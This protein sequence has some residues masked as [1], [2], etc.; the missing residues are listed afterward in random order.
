MERDFSIRNE[1][2]SISHRDES[3]DQ[4]LS[5]YY[6]EQTATNNKTVTVSDKPNLL[7][8]LVTQLQ[9][10]V[11]YLLNRDSHPKLGEA[12]KEESGFKLVIGPETLKWVALLLFVVIIL[13][14]FL[15]SQKKKGRKNPLKKKILAL[16]SE[17][18]SLKRRNPFNGSLTR[19]DEEI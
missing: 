7:E 5:R 1:V 16:E 4:I 2:D 11:N 9:S 13:M 19:V 15:S 8:S 18:N 6:S 17:I 14:L 3:L 10:S 12:P